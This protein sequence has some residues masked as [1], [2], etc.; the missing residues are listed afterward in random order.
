MICYKF[1]LMFHPIQ[2]KI[3]YLAFK[4]ESPGAG[5]DRAV[6][7]R[8]EQLRGVGEAAATQTDRQQLWSSGQ[9]EEQHQSPQHCHLSPVS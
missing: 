7:P 2:K 9:D 6:H 4:R 3:I 5:G 8:P 1:V